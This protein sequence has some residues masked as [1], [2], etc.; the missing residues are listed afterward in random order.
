MDIAFDK[1]ENMIQNIDN[2]PKAKFYFSDANPSYQN[3]PIWVNIFILITKIILSQL[4]VFLFILNNRFGTFKSRFSY[5]KNSV[6]IVDFIPY[7]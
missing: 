1:N 7:I 4:K 2:T 3:Y 6:Y 5:L